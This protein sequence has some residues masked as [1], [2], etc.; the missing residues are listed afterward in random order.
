MMTVMNSA[1]EEKKE[2]FLHKFIRNSH[3]QMSFTTT[4]PS[5]CP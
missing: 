1:M 3:K 2:N 5:Q 4:R